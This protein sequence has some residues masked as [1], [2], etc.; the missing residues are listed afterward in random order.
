MTIA[1]G[2]VGDEPKYFYVE[3]GKEALPMSSSHD[4]LRNKVQKAINDKINAGCDMDCDGDGAQDAVDMKNNGGYSSAYVQDTFPHKTDPKKGSAVYSMSGKHFQVDHKTDSD[5]DVSVG[6]P[7]P[8]EHAYVPVKKEAVSRVVCA[9]GEV[10]KEN[11]YDST[12]G[13]LTVTVIKPGLSKNNRYYSAEM[14]KKNYKV[15]EGAK[16]FADHQS[17]KEQRERP[18]GRLNDWVANLGKVW[19]EADGTVK[20]KAIVIDPPFKAKL[21]LLE[22][23]KQ[24]GTMGVSIAALC[25]SYDGQHE[26]KKAKIIESFVAAR[27]V[28][29]VT[30]AGAG[31]QVDTLESAWLVLESVDNNNDLDLIDEAAFRQRRP[32]IIEAIKKGFRKQEDD[33]KTAETQLSEALAEIVTLKASLKTLSDAKEASDL[34][35]NQVAI[36]SLLKEANLPKLA[37]ERLA[38]QFVA[39]KNLDGVKEAIVAEAAYVKELSGAVKKNNGAGDNATVMTEADE[40]KLTTDLVESFMQMGL[41]KEAAEIAAK[42]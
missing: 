37:S 3:D 2:K 19:A 11:A 15:F 9:F 40:A 24:L 13:E 8:V 41:S 29:F 35:A 27:S 28:D 7:K 6:D 39:A 42:Q 12:K 32:D 5:G 20:G 14:L 31:G 16:M 33:M 1:I 36:A 18:E 4:A 38:K 23:N 25:E 17:E 34:A 21:D 26:G 10:V 22:K 30:F